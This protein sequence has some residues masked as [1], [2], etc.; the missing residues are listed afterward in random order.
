MHRSLGSSVLWFVWPV[1][2][3]CRHRRGFSPSFRF[4]LFSFPYGIKRRSVSP[5]DGGNGSD[6]EDGCDDDD[7]EGDEDD[8]EDFFARSSISF[9]CSTRIGAKW[10]I[11]EK[12][13]PGNNISGLSFI[14]R[15]TTTCTTYIQSTGEANVRQPTDRI[16]PFLLPFS[17]NYFSM[18]S[19]E[20]R[21]KHFLRYVTSEFFHCYKNAVRAIE[22]W[23]ID[24][25]VREKLNLLI[26]KKSFFRVDCIT[27]TITRGA[28]SKSR[29]ISTAKIVSSFFETH[30]LSLQTFRCQSKIA[31]AFKKW[32]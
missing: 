27:T 21:K 24:D 23:S 12:N 1:S 25:I 26:H 10:K 5:G 16:A 20:F 8:Q 4:L 17:R 15:P 6:S 7:G 9:R 32:E 11:M 29:I 13:V 14:Y 3:F 31:K 30:R 28:K 18:N 19:H 2:L 22:L